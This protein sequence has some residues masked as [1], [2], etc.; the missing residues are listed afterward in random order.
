M[1]RRSQGQEET[2]RIEEQY[3][4]HPSNEGSS[5]GTCQ[6]GH[7]SDQILL[8]APELHPPTNRTGERQYTPYWSR[9]REA[10]QSFIELASC[11]YI[12]Q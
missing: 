8:P 10:A 9:L 6:G 11:N 5:G 3:A 4:A 12:N 7:V 1:H 2:L